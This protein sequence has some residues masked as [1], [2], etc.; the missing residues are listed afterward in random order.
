VA[1]EDTMNIYEIF[2][3]YAVVGAKPIILLPPHPFYCARNEEEAKIASRAVEIVDLAWDPE[4]V[5]I[6][7]HEL[8]S[9]QVK[10]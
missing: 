8:G 7:C 5:T 6:V 3:V 9:F 1:E 2:V 4:A 10:K